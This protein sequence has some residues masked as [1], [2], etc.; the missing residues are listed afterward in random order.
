MVCRATPS[1]TSDAPRRRRRLPEIFFNDDE[2]NDRAD[3]AVFES[4]G[5]EVSVESKPR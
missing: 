5:V 2:K 3:P 1:A 4:C